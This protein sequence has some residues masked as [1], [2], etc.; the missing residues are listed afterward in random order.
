MFEDIGDLIV[1]IF[2][3]IQLDKV[4]AI[5]NICSGSGIAVNRIIFNGKGERL[6]PDKISLL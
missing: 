5:I 3:D 6:P 2:T 4:I 1:E